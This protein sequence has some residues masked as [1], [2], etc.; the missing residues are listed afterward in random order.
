MKSLALSS[1]CR[2]AVQAGLV[3]AFV[4]GQIPVHAATHAAVAAPEGDTAPVLVSSEPVKLK[5]KHRKISRA[6]V[7]L[8]AP[9][10]KPQQLVRALR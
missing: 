9:A 4:L 1:P 7:K 10:S 6:P 5:H 2:A 3:L 8:E